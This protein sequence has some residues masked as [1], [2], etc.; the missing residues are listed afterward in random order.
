M[1]GCYPSKDKEDDKTM[2]FKV[3]DCQTKEIFLVNWEEKS[4]EVKCLCHCFEY[5]GY[6]CKHCLAVLYHLGV[7]KI[8]LRYILEQWSMNARSSREKKRPEYVHSKEL[9]HKDLCL[10]TMKINE[11]ASLCVESYD[12]AHRAVEEVL[13][14]CVAINKLHRGSM[15]DIEKENYN[16]LD[17]CISKTKGAPRE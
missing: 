8:P 5:K 1:S 3:W 15:G 2:T 11:A 6:L 14:K 16:I 9:R 17:P 12:L 13:K 7:L 4:E 10:L